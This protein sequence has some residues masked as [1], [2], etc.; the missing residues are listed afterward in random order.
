MVLKANMS[1][2]EILNTINK[3][4]FQ[5]PKALLTFNIWKHI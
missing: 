2:E 5:G 4:T 3:N 1:A